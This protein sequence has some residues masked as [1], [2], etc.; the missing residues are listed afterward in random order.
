MSGFTRA[1]KSAAKARIGLYGVSGSGKTMHALS[2]A[3]VLAGPGGSIALLDTEGGSASKYADLFEFDSNVMR[4]PYHPERFAKAL[5]AAVAGGYDVFVC[6]GV[7]PF[8]N[9]EGGVMSIVDAAKKRGGGWAEGTPAHNKLVDA[10]LTS[11]IH[12]V[13]TVRAKAET[14]VENVNGKVTYRKLG[15]KMVQRDELDYELDVLLYLDLDNS[16]TVEKS[17]K[18]DELGKNITRDDVPEW[19]VDFKGWLD[20]GTTPVVPAPKFE[21]AEEPAAPVAEQE[22]DPEREFVAGELPDDVVAAMA[23]VVPKGLRPAGKRI[24]ELDERYLEFLVEKFSIPAADQL[25][26]GEDHGAYV[27]VKAAAVLYGAWLKAQ[28]EVAA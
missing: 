3:R 26:E 4:K 18:P 14:V 25:A 12:V 22:P 24:D 11:P 19:A 21:P 16:A 2:I 15:V 10:I 27:A 6:D 8:W 1:T 13:I 23:V 20:S 28:A 7:S 9:G 5:D 17:R